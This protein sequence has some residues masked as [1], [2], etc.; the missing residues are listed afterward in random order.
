MFGDASL[1]PASERLDE[2][3]DCGRSIPFVFVVDPARTPRL[4]RNGPS[5]FFEQLHR[6]FGHAHNWLG[7]VVRALIDVNDVLHPR[8][9]LSIVLRGNHPSDLPVRVKGVF[10]SAFRTVSELTAS[11]TS[12]RTNSSANSCKVQRACPSGGSPW[13]NASS[14]RSFCSSSTRL[15]GGG[16]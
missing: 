7:R 6:H 2:R 10:L 11:T 1:S 5:G 12:R 9:I 3:E 14:L 15:L 8:H 4:G 16:S 13:A